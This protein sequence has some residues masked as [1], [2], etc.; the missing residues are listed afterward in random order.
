MVFGEEVGVVDA[1][2]VHALEVGFVGLGG[3][4]VEG[5]AVVGLLGEGVAGLVEDHGLVVLL[6]EELEQVDLLVELSKALLQALVFGLE[7]PH[8][9]PVEELL[10]GVVDLG[11]GVLEVDLVVPPLLLDYLQV[12]QRHFADRLLHRSQVLQLRVPVLLDLV[13]VLSNPAN[14]HLETHVLE[15]FV[16]VVFGR[17]ILERLDALYIDGVLHVFAADKGALG[18]QEEVSGQPTDEAH[19]ELV[20][21]GS[22]GFLEEA[23]LGGVGGMAR[24]GNANG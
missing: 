13:G 4:G 24:V 17:Y 18:E 14:L 6:L 1:E 8:V 3:V 19:L 11:V 5:E 2:F 16:V 7:L 23:H 10:P 9:L 12:G 15:E 22:V 21:A 20:G